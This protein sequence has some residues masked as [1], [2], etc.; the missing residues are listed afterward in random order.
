MATLHAGFDIGTDSVSA[1]VFSRDPEQEGRRLVYA[2]SPVFHFGNPVHALR[3]IYED[4]LALFGPEPAIFSSFTGSGGLRFAGP[5]NVPYHHDTLA[6]P[7]GASHLDPEARYV[8]HMGAKDSY[9]FEIEKIHAK[10][11]GH[12]FVPDHGTGT[13]CGGGS[14]ILIT[15]Q[16]RRFFEHE[17]P[18][19]IEG[20]TE[21]EKRRYLNERLSRIFL[22]GDGEI[23]TADRQLDVGGR[24]GVVIQSDMIHLQN[25]GEKINNILAGLYL[26]TIKNFQADV[27][28]SRILEPG[29]VS[30][31]SG[32]MFQS[33]HFVMMAGRTLGVDI[34]VSPHF[35]LVGAMGAVIRSGENR[36]TFRLSDLDRLCD[37]EKKNVKTVGP[38]RNALERVTLYDEDKPVEISGPLQIYYRNETGVTPVILGIDG[39]STTTKAVVVHKE[40][41]KIL[42]RACL[43]TNGKPLET[44][45]AIF[46]NLRDTLG[47]SLDIKAVAYTGSS[48]AFY[49]K[50]FTRTPNGSCARTIDLVKDEI[51]C[52]A[53]GVKH[54]NDRTDT[55]FELGDQDAKFTRFNP[56]GTVKKSRMNLSCMAGTGQTMQNMVEMI[57]LDIT[58]TFH[59]YA[60]SAERTP[61]VDDTCG[62]FTEAGIARLISL[63]FPKEEIAAAIAY[64]FMGGYVNTFIG[65]ES[66]GDCA[67]AQGGPFTGRAP[68]A[69]LAMHTGME[70]HAFPHRQLFGALG[71]ALAA[72][73]TL[74][75]LEQKGIPCECRFRG[76]DACLLSFDKSESSCGQEIQDS[77]GIKDCRLSVYSVGDEKI[78]TGGACPKGNTDASGKRSP[79]YVEL[80]KRILGKHLTPHCRDLRDFGAND[81]I[82]I[83]KALSFWNEKGVFYA[84]LYRNLGFDVVLSPESDDA[85]T[86]KGLSSAHSETCFP[87]K[88]AHGHAAFFLPFMRP[89]RDKILLV[90]AIGEG[91]KKY[92]FCPYVSAAGFLVK[93]ALSMDNSD[94]LIPVIYFNDPSHPMDR[95]FHKDLARV[96]G[97]RFTLKQVRKAV[98]AARKDEER[99]LAE[100]HND[101]K[102]LINRLIRKEEKIYI[103]LGRGYTL[104]DDKASSRVHELFVK[105]GLHY[106]PSFFLEP[107]NRDIEGICENMYWVQGRKIIRTNLETAMNPNFFPVRA[108]NFN[109]GS[110]SM[111]LFHEER[112]ME[113]SGKPHLILQTDG[114]SS[115][116]QFG[117]R[118]HA[119]HEVVKTYKTRP[120]NHEDFVSLSPP[121]VLKQ[122]IIGIPYMGDHSHILAATFRALGYESE[123][124]PTQTPE[125]R[126][127]ADKLGGTNIC[128]PFSFQVG[129]SLAWLNGLKNRGID[130]E[131]RAVIMEPMAKG[132]CRFG[133]YH[134]LLKKI[135]GENGFP[136]VDILSPD[137]ERDYSNLPMKDSEIIAQAK[138]LFKGV[139]CMDILYD[140]LLRTR[141]Y[142]NVKGAALAAYRDMSQKLIALIENKADL[143]TLVSFMTRGRERYENL[144][145]HRMPR[146]PI[147]AV[148]GEIFMRLN[149]HAN[150]NSIIMLEKYGLEARLAPLSLWMEYTNKASIQNFKMANHWKKYVKA[151]VK[152]RYMQRVSRTLFEPF[153]EYLK[154]REPHDSEHIIDHVE[155]DLVY[156]GNIQG[157]SPLSIGEA[158]MFASGKL[159]D[160]SGIYHVGPFG[161]MQETAATSQIQSV[162][163]RIRQSACT[164]NEKIIPFMDAIFGDSELSNLEAEIAVFSEKCHV[165]HRLTK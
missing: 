12:V 119:N 164:I 88:M 145:D 47:E 83:P 56:D 115:N 36:S 21:K 28:K 31:A 150:N 114:H 158:Y 27:L 100:I 42:A 44:I 2:P 4:I 53:L 92:K 121:V 43:Y 130:P 49:H 20:K 72:S 62:V 99:F 77:C 111:L 96:Y 118:I 61:V 67:S 146:K 123:V 137:A 48:G 63:G 140:A 133:Q 24:C 162:T 153:R 94:V 59:E 38:L 37:S 11:E 14:G 131:L 82:M 159:I 132:P 6:I 117:T 50:L 163:R 18:L 90:N 157:E 78:I 156:D 129:D 124:M 134:V 35:R 13:K 98:E 87:V 110:D 141:P 161:C 104:F 8:F 70:I 84:S 116:A 57:G 23:E 89:G 58:S 95:A 101:G 148:T 55:I 81:R 160:I 113:K 85:I 30:L 5:L 17:F 69:A 155:K 165:K 52:H 144:L 139:F 22:R 107:D 7:A 45:Q 127:Y 126:L 60:L 39:G 109:C 136:C 149:P 125:S 154:G 40:T 68:L 106:I 86:D 66:F 91:E 138:D 103:G 80:Y 32:G 102:A 51:T 16:C 93:D 29:A 122:K 10:G 33:P 74:R 128:Q 1:A 142:E 54:Y 3:D 25:S 75:N 112:I 76:F 120:V 19:D 9:F 64:G 73:R 151:V 15:K 79:D 26:R 34:K 105:N 147:I 143:K 108:T 65:S 152:K 135:I 71:A 41:L 97:N 46:R